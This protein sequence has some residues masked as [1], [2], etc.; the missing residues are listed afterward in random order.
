VASFVICGVA[1]EATGFTMIAPDLL[2]REILYLTKLPADVALGIF[3]L[4]LY[5][6]LLRPRCHRLTNIGEEKIIEKG[7]GYS[8]GR[9]RHRRHYHDDRGC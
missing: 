2:R 6:E 4:N 9:V 5:P 8:N 1:E 3:E 7:H